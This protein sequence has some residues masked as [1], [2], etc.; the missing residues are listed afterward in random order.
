VPD[1]NAPQWKP[2]YIFEFFQI[3]FHNIGAFFTSSRFDRI[4]HSF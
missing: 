1:P 4:G 2:P 3:I